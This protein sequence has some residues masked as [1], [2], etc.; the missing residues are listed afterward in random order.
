MV[1]E[2][3]G[4]SGETEKKMD[5]TGVPVDVLCGEVRQ[6]RQETWS[7]QVSSVE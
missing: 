7:K 4:E 1:V 5:L 2:V 3:N 6:E